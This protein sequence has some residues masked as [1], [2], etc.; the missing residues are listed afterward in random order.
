M[1]ITF[2]AIASVTVTNA[3]QATIEFTSI[4][5]TYTD[6]VLL[7]SARTNDSYGYTDIGVTLN[8][9]NRNAA[10]VVYGVDGAAGSYSPSTAQNFFSE[11]S[12]AGSTANT[13]GN[14]MVYIPNYTS[15]S[16]KSLGGDAVSEN[17]A[18][19]T[20]MALSAG[21]FTVT[22]AVTTIT[23]TPGAS[24]SFVQHS[25]ATLYGIKNTV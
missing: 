23:L 16:N 9:T 24:T 22:S 17:N 8:S 2:T 12:G 13:F 20:V 10:K 21:L 18:S 5:N 6:L 1:A 15:S 19:L 14:G 7:L 3:T 4:P 25:S 11:A